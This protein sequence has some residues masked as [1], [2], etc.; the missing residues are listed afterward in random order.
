MTK[1]EIYSRFG[2]EAGKH[3]IQRKLD[4]PEAERLL[5]MRRHPEAPDCEVG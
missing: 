4:L 3:I 1:L 5:E 2:E